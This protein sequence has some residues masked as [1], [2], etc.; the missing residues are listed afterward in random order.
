MC[1]RR[2]PRREVRR[3]QR[4]YQ[5][6]GLLDSGARVA[7]ERRLDQVR[8]RRGHRRI[9]LAERAERTLPLLAH[10][11][12]VRRT[13]ERHLAGQEVVEC[14]AQGEQVAPPVHHVGVHRLLVRHVVRRADAL[15]DG[16]EL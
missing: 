11:L 5:L 4:V 7:R 14:R 2:E 6:P 12:V 13:G 15:V 3:D 10:H 1:E 9:R 8:D 16:G